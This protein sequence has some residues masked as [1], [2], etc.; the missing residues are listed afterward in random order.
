MLSVVSY[1]STAAH[2]SATLHSLPVDQLAEY[3]W[4]HF[5][6]FPP[7]TNGFVNTGYNPTG[8][9]GI[10]IMCLSEVI[11]LPMDCCFSKLAL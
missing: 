1:Q 11:C 3:S 5:R 6:Y 2:T 10:R 8:R 7:I 9:L 4:S